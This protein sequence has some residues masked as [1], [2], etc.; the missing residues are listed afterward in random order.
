MENMFQEARQFNSNIVNWI[1]SKVLNMQNMFKDC[2]MFNS[3]LSKWD[4]VRVTNFENVFYNAT[5]FTGTDNKLFCSGSWE[6]SYLTPNDMEKSGVTDFYSCDD[7]FLRSINIHLAVCDI[8]GNDDYK[9]SGMEKNAVITKYGEIEDWDV[10]R[11]TSLNGVFSNIYEM[12]SPWDLGDIDISK[13]DTSRVTTMEEAF[14]YSQTFNSDISKWNVSCVQSLVGTFRLAPK[15]NADLSKWQIS[16][17]TSLE[18]TFDFALE[19][20]GDL[21][22]WQTSR[23][24]NLIGTFQRTPKFNGDVSKWDVS[25][26]EFMD[27]S[28]FQFF[29]SFSTTFFPYF[30]PFPQKICL[31]HYSSLLL[32][33]LFFFTFFTLQRLNLLLHSTRISR[34]GMSPQ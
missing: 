18:K 30:L 22:K 5:S 20:N 34:S 16:S 13:W 7:K 19:F 6:S 32:F 24:N 1:T 23:V 17:V 29:F 26:V 15:F 3:D 4:V 10:S 21:S 14:F 25:H 27:S 33:A 11:C 31:S 12:F 9:C 2:P 28:T 8:F